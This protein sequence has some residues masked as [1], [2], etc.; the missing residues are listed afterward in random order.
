[1][2]SIQLDVLKPEVFYTIPNASFQDSYELEVSVIDKAGNECKLNK[3]IGTYYIIKEGKLLDEN[4]TF[5]LSNYGLLVQ[6]DG[7]VDVSLSCPASK[8]N[9]LQWRT[10]WDG[11]KAKITIDFEHYETSKYAPNVYLTGY[12]YESLFETLPPAS[13]Y[14][15]SNS[16][17]D[18]PVGGHRIFAMKNSLGGWTTERIVA[19]SYHMVLGE[20]VLIRF[21][22]GYRSDISTNVKYRIYNLFV[23][24]P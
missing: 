18:A 6:K 16:S 3:K 5:G 19:S 1:M 7:Y 4:Y 9:Y 12:G 23:E 20:G 13:D 14:S 17:Y 24:W 8:P 15:Y 11:P 21:Q 10:Y 22:H 2:G